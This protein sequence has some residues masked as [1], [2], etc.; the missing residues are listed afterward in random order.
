M[1]NQLVAIFLLLSLLAHTT[2]FAWSNQREQKA[3][4]AVVLINH[5]NWVVSRV[6]QNKDNAAVIEEEYE[7]LTDNN[8]N[9]AT[10]EDEEI[11]REILALMNVFTEIR[12]VIMD[13]DTLHECVELQRKGAV[14]KAIPN[15]GA[16]LVPNPYLVALRLAEA[17]ATSYMRYKDACNEILIGFKEKKLEID[18]HRLSA[19]NA[20][21]EELFWRQW[22]LVQK[23]GL[24]DAWRTSRS[25]CRE[26]VAIISI[27]EQGGNAKNLVY[28]Y[29]KRNEQRFAYL[30]IYW[31]Y[32]A[33][34]ALNH[35]GNEEMS[36]VDREDAIYSCEQFA[37]RHK[38]ILRKDRICA[39]VAMML[40]GA[41]KDKMSKS[42]MIE[43]LDVVM[44][45]TKTHDWDL[46]YFV[47]GAYAKMGDID[48]AENILAGMVDNL[49]ALLMKYETSKRNF[50]VTSMKVLAVDK[51]SADEK[52]QS[53]T[54]LASFPSYGLFSCR[55]MLNKLRYEKSSTKELAK[56]EMLSLISVGKQ[57]RVSL[58]E[59]LW[60]ADTIGEMPIPLSDE[61]KRVSVSA[62]DS[63]VTFG[64]MEP[65]M[66][67]DNE[68]VRASVRAFRAN[69]AIGVDC[70]PDIRLK[71]QD[72]NHYVQESTPSESKGDIVCRFKSEKV[73]R[74]I[75][76]FEVVLN[77]AISRDE[78]SGWSVKFV[79]D[80]NQDFNVVNVS[81]VY[82]G[83][84]LV[85]ENQ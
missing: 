9:L 70:S 18:K 71:N 22:Q 26:L 76:R 13:L 74:G 65:W 8:I 12:K 15:P 19:L 62:V 35:V 60:Y 47:A 14:Y 50:D 17:A 82:L 57:R 83:S 16:I 4:T 58:F 42:E 55:F 34:W 30:P 27:A 6:E 48:K 75:R 80:V 3:E 39:T 73:L 40:I 77:Y 33:L 46:A 1:K 63:T 59:R 78:K 56:K 24:E 85:F 44:R 25:D 45:N 52:D 5:L 49:E 51:S 11:A 69:D 20:I 66:I 64:L 29:L 67:T 81:K 23:H 38:D 84:K 54:H 68:M 10:I 36:I 72:G 21:N 41:K 2:G 61:L 43:Q 79:F 53:K 32:R 7:N 28:S 37:K 31:Y